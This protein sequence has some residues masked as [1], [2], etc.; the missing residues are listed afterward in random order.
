MFIDWHS[1]SK[2]VLYP[3]GD[4][5]QKAPDHDGLKAVAERFAGFNKYS[6]MQA[7][8][9]YPTTGTTE[10]NAYGKYG[11]PAFTI[12]TGSTFHQSDKEFAQTVKENL[13]VLWY[14]GR[15]ADDPYK[16]A[17]APDVSS[18]RIDGNT[19]HAVVSGTASKDLVAG[20]ELVLDPFAKPGTGIALT[21]ADGAFDGSTEQASAS[22]TS[23]TGQALSGWKSLGAGE[24]GLVFVR[25][26]DAQGNWGPLMPQWAN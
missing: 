12:E 4:T 18:I 6:P 19:L 9:L 21:P 22:L 13:P 8:N 14:A 10:D 2:L 25:A 24:R 5:K 3:W 15:I 11:V 17:Q 20:A 23:A 26:R 1:Y 16:R 7:V